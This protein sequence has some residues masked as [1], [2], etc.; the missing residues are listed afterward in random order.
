L[1]I[2]RPRDI[3]C[4]KKMKKP[5]LM[6]SYRFAS[7]IFWALLLVHCQTPPPPPVPRPENPDLAVADPADVAKVQQHYAGLPGDSEA[8]Y[9]DISP[10]CKIENA[11]EGSYLSRKMY[12]TGDYGRELSRGTV[13]VWN[14]RQELIHYG[15]YDSKGELTGIAANFYNKLPRQV[16]LRRGDAEVTRSWYWAQNNRKWDSSFTELEIK[17]PARSHRI[18]F[19]MSRDGLTIMRREETINGIANG[20]QFLLTETTKPNCIQ[21]TG[22]T[23]KKIQRICPMNVPL[24]PLQ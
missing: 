8:L 13:C 17:Y 3:S 7:H 14:A 24:I 2:K 5:A 22:G 10:R 9:R 1:I 20:V 4:K 23:E 15:E 21:R 11:R 12:F 6:Q 18:Y 16:K 19:E